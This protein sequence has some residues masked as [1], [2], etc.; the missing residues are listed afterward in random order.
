MGHPTQVDD[1]VLDTYDLLYDRVVSST[2][3]AGAS[4]LAAIQDTVRWPQAGGV[5]QMA[6]GKLVLPRV[7]LSPPCLSFSPA[8]WETG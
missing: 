4:E 6:T 5:T 3:G 8:H 7:S 2:S 1:T